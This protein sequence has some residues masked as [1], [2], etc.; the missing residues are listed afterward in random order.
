[1]HHTTIEL[2]VHMEIMLQILLMGSR[3]EHLQQIKLL[4]NLLAYQRQIMVLDNLLGILG[5]DI[6]P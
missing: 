6:L 5:L 4:D 3:L 2:L 1:M